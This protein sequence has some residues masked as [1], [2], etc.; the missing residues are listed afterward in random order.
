MKNNSKTYIIATLVLIIGIFIGASLFSSESQ[1][2]EHNH[3]QLQESADTTAY[4]CS[5]H[6]QIRK[7]EPGDCPICGM[8]LIP[9]SSMEESVDPDAIKMSKTARQLAGVET[10]VVGNQTLNSGLEFSGRLAINQDKTQSVTANVKSRIEKLYVNEDGEK[11]NK[12]QVIVELYAPDIQ[13]LKE[14]LDLAKRQENQELLKSIKRKIKNYELSINDIESIK[15]GSLKLKSPSTGVVTNLQ[16]KQGDHLKADQNLMRITDLSTLWAIVDVYE[17]DLEKIEIGDELK[18][19]MSNYKSTSGRVTFISPILDDKSRSAK[20][21]VVIDNSDFEL[22]PGVF[23]NATL[24]V[25]NKNAIPPKSLMIPKSAVLWTGKRSVI[26]QQLENE[27]GVFFKMKEVEISRSSSDLVEVVSG[28][29]SGDEIV[30]YGAFSIDAEAQL[31]GKPSM[32][33]QDD[34]ISNTVHQHHDMAIQNKN[35]TE[36]VAEEK[37]D[38]IDK[39]KELIGEY[40]LLKN[41]LVSDDFMASKKHYKQVNTLISKVSSQHFQNI[42]KLNSIDEL[43]EEFKFLSD[44]MI[45]LLEKFNPMDKTIYIQLCPMADNGDGARWLSFSNQIRNPYYGASMLKCGSVTDSIN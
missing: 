17:S 14:E 10:L 25:E 19:K 11:V 44:E 37:T 38:D 3:G 15:N 26:Y 41:K 29:Q 1:N 4:T 6:P 36:N 16:V 24:S 12:G 28:L 42:K 30:K 31:S 32:M 18:I 2:K 40:Q 27:N 8:D 33:N 20:A 43:R 23:I 35:D 5:M 45:R 7:D 21:R 13:V 34:S 39:M 9:A 22:K